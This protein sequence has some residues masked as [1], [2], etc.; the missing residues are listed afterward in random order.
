MLQSVASLQGYRILAQDGVVGKVQD[1]CVDDRTWTVRYLVV[2]TG[3]ILPGRR[4]LL[5]PAVIGGVDWP[6]KVLAVQVTVAQVK[7]SPP[8]DEDAPVS[9]RHEAELAHHFGW[10]A[11]W[12]PPT[13][14]VGPPVPPAIAEPSLRRDRPTGPPGEPAGGDPHL[15]SVQEV[16]G[17]G[18]HARDGAIGHV[19]DFILDDETWALRYLVVD[20]RDW[21]PGK[22]VLV[23]TAWIAGVRWADRAVTLDLTRQSVQDSPAYDPAAPVNRRLEE[24][25]Y[26][27]YGRPRSWK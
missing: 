20:T 1:F 4:V 16:R 12:P 7:E 21:L 9:R 2:D 23:A 26:D 17:Y 24:R 27:Y 13:V 15:R 10:P 5:S 8:I 11:T 25:L 6:A 14:P 19:E 3:R 22:K 18:I